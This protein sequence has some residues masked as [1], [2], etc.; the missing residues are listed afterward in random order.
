MMMMMI[1]IM[2]ILFHSSTTFTLERKER[3]KE[4]KK[5]KLARGCHPSTQEVGSK[6]RDRDRCCLTPLIIT[7]LWG[8]RQM[9]LQVE[10]SLVYTKKS[11]LKKKKKKKRRQRRRKEGRKEDKKS[12]ISSA[13]L[14][15]FS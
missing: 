5:E 13:I 15:V 14:Q 2:E 9:K 1:M 8:Q 7:A 6:D 11:C 4:G 10:T 3:G 12:R